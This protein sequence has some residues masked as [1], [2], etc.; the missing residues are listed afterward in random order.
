[1][2]FAAPQQYN[3][4]NNNYQIN[5]NHPPPH[6]QHMNRTTTPRRVQFSIHNQ[7]SANSDSSNKSLPN[8]NPLQAQESMP[9]RPELDGF[10]SQSQ[11]Y[12]GPPKLSKDIKSI[13]INSK[14]KQG[15]IKSNHSTPESIVNEEPIPSAYGP[16][17]HH[18]KGNNSEYAPNTRLPMNTSN[19]IIVSTNGKKQNLINQES[20]KIQIHNENSESVMSSTPTAPMT[21]NTD[22]KPLPITNFTNNNVYNPKTQQYYR[23]GTISNASYDHI[24]GLYSINS[25]TQVRSNHMTNGSMGSS[26]PPPLPNA[27]SI[28]LSSNM[29]VNTNEMKLQQ[30]NQGKTTRLTLEKNF[31]N[32]KKSFETWM[33]CCDIQ[34]D[35]FGYY[36][37]LYPLLCEIFAESTKCQRVPKQSDLE[38]VIL[39]HG[40]QKMKL[41]Q[42]HQMNH[43]SG[44][45]S[46]DM[47]AQHHQLNKKNNGKST[48]Q[49]ITPTTP[50]NKQHM[51]TVSSGSF[52]HHQHSST[53]TFDF[54]NPNSKPKYLVTIKYKS[55]IKFFKW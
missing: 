9:Y 27:T 49:P 3:R 53:I 20:H 34:D 24:P 33:G 26:R 2:A 40:A 55:F 37:A 48:Q 14:M 41:S 10:G 4:N 12:G 18:H 25:Q 39:K 23:Q 21:N 46:T 30:E 47:L 5:N 22:D 13:E 8:L 36:S 15:A 29:S 52:G 6:H 7:G 1:M 16:H 54:D 17:G 38:E 11:V 28:A 45:I 42:L 50:N 31:S 44:T 43:V 51:A 35:T 19:S 32:D